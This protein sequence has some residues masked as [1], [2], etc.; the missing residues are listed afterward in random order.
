MDYKTIA[1]HIFRAGIEKVL[2]G[3]LISESVSLNDDI[4]NIN[5][6]SFSLGNIS[7]IY[8]VGAGKASALMAQQI[9]EILKDRITK[10]LVIVKY[11]HSCNLKLVD[12]AEAGHPLPDLKGVE[13]TQKIIAILEKAGENDLVICLLSGGGSALMVDYPENSNID[14]II[15]LNDL[16]IR[17]GA[18]ISEINTVRKH[19]SHI[20]GGQ[21]S[22]VAYPAT[23]VSLILSDVIGDPLDAIASGPTAADPTTYRDALHILYKYNLENKAPA[24]IIRHLNEG[25]SGKIKETPKPDDAVLKKTYNY[26]IGNNRLALEAAAKKALYYNIEPK[27][28]TDRL[29]GETESACDFIVNTTLKIKEDSTEKKPLCLIFGGETTVK[30]SGT[31]TGGR[32]QHLAL[33]CAEKIAGISGITI[34]SGGTDGTD[35]P[36]DAAGAIVD[37]NTVLMANL[38]QLDIHK[39]IKDFNSYKFFKEVEGHIFTGPTMTNVM[40]IVIVIVE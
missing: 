6:L 34:L 17:S 28:I 9:E 15:A 31:G 26:I 35:G 3:K 18:S 32:N 12:V 29:Q 30:V 33:L 27:I 22:G 19:L 23:V 8:I 25:Q 21:L 20:K 1:N 2:P 37:S 16:L 36:T 24:N 5:D 13:A 39:Y 10:G 7:D 4:L 11:G 40:D 14:E 38:K